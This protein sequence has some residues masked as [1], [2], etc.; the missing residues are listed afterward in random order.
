MLAKVGGRG[1]FAASTGRNGSRVCSGE[2]RFVQGLLPILINFMAMM[3]TLIIGVFIM[4][5][6][7][8]GWAQKVAIN[9]LVVDSTV[10]YQFDLLDGGRL[11]GTVQ[12]LEGE[13]IV[14]HTRDVGDVRVEKKRI[15]RVTRMSE[16]ATATGRYWFENPHGTRYLFS[17]S[18][19][20]LRKGEGYYQNTYLLLNSV[21]VGVTNNI[22]VGGGIELL[23]MFVRDSPGPIFFLTAKGG[24]KVAKDLYLGG[25]ALYTSIPA[26]FDD[27]SEGER[28]GVGLLFTQATYGNLDHQVTGS[29]GWAY[30][31]GDIA[32]RPVLT[33]SGLTRVGRKI[34]LL[35]ENWFVPD[36]IGYYAVFSYGVR[37]MGESIAVDLAFLNNS[38]IAEGIVIGIPWVDFVVK[39]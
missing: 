38:D 33:L 28:V 16:A 39:F 8:D 34:A 15:E 23:S 14:V 7:L 20:P 27:G 19:I 11:M 24:G 9:E 26:D 6:Q 1:I 4:L 2:H 30:G 17:S 36:D 37:F 25:G 29:V 3:R 12:A 22:S 5:F 18:A 21:A 13:A 31:E 32:Q 10:V 35:S